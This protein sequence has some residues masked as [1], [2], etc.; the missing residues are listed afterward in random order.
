MISGMY[1]G[2]IVRRV[3]SHLTSRGLLFAGAQSKDLSTPGCFLT[4]YVSEIGG[5]V[6]ILDPRHNYN[7]YVISFIEL[8]FL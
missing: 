8:L 4:K 2:E 7:N 3:L 6:N 5:Y 1:M